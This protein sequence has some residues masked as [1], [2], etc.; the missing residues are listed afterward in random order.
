M[1]NLAYVSK[2]VETAIAKQLQHYLFT[3]DLFPAS[4]SVYRPNHSTETALLRVT[5]D[6]LLN[7]NDQRVN[8][9]L[10]LDLS[11]AFDTVDY[12]TLLHR[13]QFSLGI[14]RKVISWFKS[15]V[16]RISASVDQ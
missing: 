14:Q 15:F 9:L 8:F 1:S 2:L 3:N 4:Q 12:D 10:L 11:A 13:I 5:N 6:I 7:I 16:G